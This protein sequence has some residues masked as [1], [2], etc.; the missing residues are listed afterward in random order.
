MSLT[1]RLAPNCTDP[2]KLSEAKND[3]DTITHLGFNSSVSDTGLLRLREFTNLQDL[4]LNDTQVTDAGV[5]AI[6][7]TQQTF[8]VQL[9]RLA[10]PDATNI[11]AG[12]HSVWLATGPAGAAGDQDIVFLADNPGLSALLVLG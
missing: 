3:T 4:S 9:T 8:H 2:C 6:Q 7:Q 10:Y 12:V 11:E 1:I 5:A